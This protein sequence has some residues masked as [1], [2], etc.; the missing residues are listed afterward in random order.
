MSSSQ[1]AINMD[2]SEDQNRLQQVTQQTQA[3]AVYDNTVLYLFN[4]INLGKNIE[5]RI[6][7]CKISLLKKN[8]SIIK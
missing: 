6:I 4:I 8:I 1:V 7:I 2:N 3:M 5:W